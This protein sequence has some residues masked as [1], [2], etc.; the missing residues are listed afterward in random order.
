[1]ATVENS[2]FSDRIFLLPP[3]LQYI[4]FKQAL[5]T[6]SADLSAKGMYMI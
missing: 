5:T 3:N 2:E 1:M 4:S 6:V